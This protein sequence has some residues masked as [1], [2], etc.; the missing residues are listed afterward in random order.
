MKVQVWARRIKGRI[1]PWNRQSP[2]VVGSLSTTVKDAPDER[3]VV[4]L[5][6]QGGETGSL[7][8]FEPRLISAGGRELKFSGYECVEYCWVIQEWVCELHNAAS[9][10]DSEIRT[11]YGLPTHPLP[12]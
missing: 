5:S 3:K 1:Q 12:R 10:S 7:Q 9:V 4:V 8:L 2:P 11:R 6:V